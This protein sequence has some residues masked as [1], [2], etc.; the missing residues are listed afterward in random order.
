MKNI[1]ILGKSPFINNIELDRLKYELA[2]INKPACKVSKCFAIDKINFD[3]D[4]DTEIISPRK[5]HFVVS[6]PNFNKNKKNILGFC[7]FT[8]SIAINWCYLNDYDNVYLVGVDHNEEDEYFI[9]YDG[10]RSWS[11]KLFTPNDHIN[12]KNFIYQFK[13]KIN[14]YQTNPNTNWDLDYIDIK[15]LYKER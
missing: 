5:Q 2:S 13:D 6:K 12:L 1:I 9:H 3:L 11:K 10:T 7:R 8:V 14:I 15:K 4:K